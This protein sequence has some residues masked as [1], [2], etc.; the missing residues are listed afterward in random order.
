MRVDNRHNGAYQTVS[1]SDSGDTLYR[2]DRWFVTAAG[3]SIGASQAGP[4]GQFTELLVLGGGAGNTGWSLGQKIESINIQDLA[5]VESNV[6]LSAYL[7]NGSGGPSTVNWAAYYP[8]AGVDNWGS[9]PLPMGGT[10]IR[11]GSWTINSGLAQYSAE[12]SLP[13]SPGAERGLA[14]LFSGGAFTAGQLTITGVQLEAA[15][16]GQTVGSSFEIVPYDIELL[17]C[18]RYLPSW[19]ASSMGPFW[20]QAA[21]ASNLVFNLPYPVTPR[22]PNSLSATLV[23]SVVPGGTEVLNY[24][25]AA[26]GGGIGTPGTTLALDIATLNGIRLLL[27]GGSGF[28]AGATMLSLLFIGYTYF[29]VTGFEL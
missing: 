11:S 1:P 29:Y 5:Q 25:D 9:S 6:I 14:I 27:T 4:N 22:V 16:S 3:A 12:F 15:Q 13:F 18:A 2:V 23:Q 20:C 7:N 26:T 19:R 21:T 8:S 17:R 10:L 28:T 24:A